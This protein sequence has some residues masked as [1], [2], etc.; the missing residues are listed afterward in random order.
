VRLGDQFDPENVEHGRTRARAVPTR[1]A[2]LAPRH[3]IS[4]RYHFAVGLGAKLMRRWPLTL[5][6]SAGGIAGAMV[7]GA[8]PPGR[9]LGPDELKLRHDLVVPS[10]CRDLA[11]NG[12]TS[13]N[14]AGRRGTN[15]DV[16][17]ARLRW[18]VAMDRASAEGARG[19]RNTGAAS[20]LGLMGDE[21]DLVDQVCSLAYEAR[22]TAQLRAADE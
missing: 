16:A 1:G 21:P 22:R 14:W 19:R 4:V 13:R 5:L 15:L 9:V 12:G 20:L 2:P 10:L 18:K 11:R 17:F 6:P 7:R 3:Q 8:F